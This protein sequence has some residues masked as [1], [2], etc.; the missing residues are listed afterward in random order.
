MGWFA[1]STVI[2][3]MSFMMK[4]GREDSLIVAVLFPAFGRLAWSLAV[5]FIVVATTTQFGNGK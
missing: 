4:Y 5:S 1:S 2:L 3:F